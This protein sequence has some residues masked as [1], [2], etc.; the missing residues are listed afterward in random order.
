MWLFSVARSGRALGEAIEHGRGNWSHLDR[1]GGL[2][3]WDRLG[4]LS[5][6]VAPLDTQFALTPVKTDEA[7]LPMRIAHRLGSAIA[8]GDLPPGTR[9]PSEPVLARQLGVS[10]ASLREALQILEREHLLSRRPGVGTYVTP[11]AALRLNRGLEQLTSTTQMVEQMGFIPGTIDVRVRL[12][13]APSELADALDL[14]PGTAVVHLT[15][16][17]LA[18]GTPFC[19]CEEYLPVPIFEAASADPH[20]L[21][22]APSL[23][24]YLSTRLAIEI[25]AAETEILPCVATARQAE[26]LGIRRGH[27]LLLLKHIHLTSSDQPVLVARNYHNPDIIRFRIT[28]RSS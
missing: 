25:A 20:E 12:A 4:K 21:L 23:F 11:R 18:S 7:P 13:A 14:A 19:Y 28:R 17:R 26:R 24:R 16:T 3:D 22:T 2:T 15:R 1:S 27:P 8:E 9:L 10:R 5:D 6:M